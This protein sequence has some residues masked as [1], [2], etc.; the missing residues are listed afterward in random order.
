MGKREGRDK[1][2]LFHYLTLWVAHPLGC[3]SRLEKVKK[4]Y[5]WQRASAAGS[6]WSSN[7]FPLLVETY[8]LH[9]ASK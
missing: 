8:C 4:H 6:V 7:D 3:P 5:F 2:L 9:A 1:T